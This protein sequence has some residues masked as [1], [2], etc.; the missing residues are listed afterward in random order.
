MLFPQKNLKNKDFWKKY[1][2]SILF[3]TKIR[4]NGMIQTNFFWPIHY[5]CAHNFTMKIRERMR[6]VSFLSFIHSFCLIPFSL[7]RWR[8]INIIFTT[9]SSFATKERVIAKTI[10]RNRIY[11]SSTQKYSFSMLICMAAISYTGHQKL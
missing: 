5:K 7:I 1:E 4:I 3:K 10:H 6:T 2:I 11:N 9:C 8:K